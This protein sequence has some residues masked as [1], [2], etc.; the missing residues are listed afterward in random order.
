M[1][2][3]RM[4]RCALIALVS[5]SVMYPTGSLFSDCQG[6]ALPQLVAMASNR[7]MWC[8][9]LAS[10]SCTCGL[11]YGIEPSGFTMNKCM[12]VKCRRQSETDL[13]SR[14]AKTI[15]IFEHLSSLRF[16]LSRVFV[17]IVLAPDL[18]VPRR[19]S[20]WA[21]IFCLNVS[22]YVDLSVK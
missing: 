8:A 19:V 9:K 15:H 14:G 3:D 2:G 10:L 4:V 16:V 1:P 13:C 17:F 11:F 7:A 12:Y 5:D 18:Q 20:I 6:V 21:L 22:Y